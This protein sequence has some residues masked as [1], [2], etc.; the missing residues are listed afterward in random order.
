MS[1]SFGYKVACA[2]FGKEK[3]LDVIEARFEALNLV[4]V[5]NAL[6]RICELLEHR[7]DVIYI[8]SDGRRLPKDYSDEEIKKLI[9]ENA[10]D[11]LEKVEAVQRYILR[12]K[13]KAME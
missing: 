7:D 8:A 2:M 11:A 4:D 12:L 13:Q 10:K 9:L 1:A 3:V 6:E 5:E